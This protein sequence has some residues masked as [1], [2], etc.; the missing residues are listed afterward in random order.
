MSYIS[1]NEVLPQELV[2]KILQYISGKS[3]YI[4]CK[5]K[6]NWGSKS[7]AKQYYQKRNR[8]ISTKYRQGVSVKVLAA[9]YFLSEKSIQRIIRGTKEVEEY[10]YIT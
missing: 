5:E 3:I 8:E 1:A 10:R 2:E 7:K 6:Q 4:P 9:E